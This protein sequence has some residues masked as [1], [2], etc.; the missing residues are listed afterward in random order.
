MKPTEELMNRFYQHLGDLF[1][2]I[3]K[4]DKVVRKEEE[5]VL[6]ELITKDWLDLEDSEDVFHTDAA[7]LIEFA[8][9]ALNER[10]ADAEDR[11]MEFKLFKQSHEHLF[12][13]KVNDL[14]MRTANAI[15]SSF[16]GTNKS[17]LDM[18]L[19]LE[20]MLKIETH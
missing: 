14:I 8:F 16:S 19:R 5:R 12:T 17:E 1:Y 4:S 3:A 2:A 6:K 13:S 11:F 10:Q 20:L 7:H 9:D 15:A 18:L